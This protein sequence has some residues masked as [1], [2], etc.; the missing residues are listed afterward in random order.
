MIHKKAELSDTYN[1]SFL[2]VCLQ[3]CFSFFASPKCKDVSNRYKFNLNFVVIININ[4]I[5]SVY[6]VVFSVES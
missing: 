1:R 6:L 2:F 4:N 5:I 3:V